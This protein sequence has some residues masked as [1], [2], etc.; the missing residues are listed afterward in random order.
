MMLR[1]CVCC[2]NTALD[3]FLIHWIQPLMTASSVVAEGANTF[4][5]V[6]D[7]LLASSSHQSLFIS[8]MP[9]A[10]KHD[11]R[12]DRQIIWKGS[13]T[14]WTPPSDPLW[15]GLMYVIYC[16]LNAIHSHDERQSSMNAQIEHQKFSCSVLRVADETHNYEHTEASIEQNKQE[17][18][19]VTSIAIL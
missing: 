2:I 1:N 8:V 17:E 12:S 10:T 11:H 18:R 13:K 3:K 5:R 14:A 6:V 16:W 9:M 4:V 19:I 7:I 15:L